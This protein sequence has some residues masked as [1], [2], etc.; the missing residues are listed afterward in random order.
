MA[1]RQFASVT[2]QAS[3]TASDRS[4]PGVRARAV[5]RCACR[6]AAIAYASRMVAF[7]A[8]S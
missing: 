3:S 7:F 1:S 8:R 2:P 5:T 4:M 6:S